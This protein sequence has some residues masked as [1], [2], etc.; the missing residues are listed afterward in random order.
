MNKKVIYTC[1]T[2]NYDTLLQPIVV[3]ESFDYICFS[4][5]INSSKVGV[6][7][8]RPISYTG[9]SQSRLSRYPKLQPYK[10]L[11]EYDYSV[12]MDANL[13]I[14]AK[15]FYDVISHKIDCGCK[16]A[17][18]PHAIPPVDCIYDE[19]LHAYWDMKASLIQVLSMSLYLK[20]TGFP[21]HYGLYENNIIFRKHNDEQV[22]SISNQWWS[23]YLEHAPRDQF[24]LMYVYWNNRFKPD[25]LFGEGVCA[26]NCEYLHYCKHLHEQKNFSFLTKVILKLH[27]SIFPI[28]KYLI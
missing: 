8:I 14:I 26:R 16:I 28:M 19:L 12:Y 13:Q 20:K 1:C 18:V 9:V 23:S 21:R 4:N 6:W 3:D 17:Q 24:S 22:V 7:E 5:D 25:L 15:E 10:V 2:G 11:P 27:R